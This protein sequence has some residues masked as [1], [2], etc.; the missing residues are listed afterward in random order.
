MHFAFSHHHFSRMFF[1][2]SLLQADAAARIAGKS[3]IIAAA[4]SG[5][6]ADVLSCLIADTNCVNER[7][8]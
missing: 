4:E 7:N 1:L 3:G 8:G 6:V 2:E 5:D